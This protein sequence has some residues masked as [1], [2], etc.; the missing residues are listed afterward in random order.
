ML[1]QALRGRVALATL[2]VA[3][4]WTVI[5][6][7]LGAGFGRLVPM[8]FPALAVGAAIVLFL[9][10][11]AGY[12]AFVW[13]LWFLTPAVRRLVDYEIGWTPVSVVMLTPYFVALI[14]AVAL[15]GRVG[16]LSLPQLL[17][18]GLTV[19]GIAYAFV[20]GLGTVGARRR[21]IRS[22][23]MAGSG[24]FRLLLHGDVATLRPLV[25]DDASCF[26]PWPDCHLHLRVDPVRLSAALGCGL[27]G[28][29][30]YVLD[31]LARALP[32]ARVQHHE[33]AGRARHGLDGGFVGR[34]DPARSA[35]SPRGHSNL[36]LRCCSA[37]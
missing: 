8:A 29:L 11:P 26:P 32:R 5:L 36:A 15:I 12:L 3:A 34:H 7:M 13:W 33:C 22:A 25:L 6:I 4:F 2:I 17:S 24:A 23:D 1:G 30:G 19:A 18:L 10:A 28:Q 20:I 27:D 37:R 16:T 21:L 9:R 14:P 35:C 31:R